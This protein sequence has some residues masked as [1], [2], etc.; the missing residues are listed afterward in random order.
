MTLGTLG[1]L[2]ECRYGFVSCILEEDMIS[3]AF[4]HW[5]FIYRHK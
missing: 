1:Y 3:I 4:E 5:F 2:R